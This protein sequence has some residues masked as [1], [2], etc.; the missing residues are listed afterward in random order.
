MVDS[1]P[2][3]RSQKLRLR[4]MGE[5]ALTH[6]AG[7][8]VAIAS[9]K[10]RALLAILA[11]SP[12][13]RASRERL[14]ALLWGEHDDNAA[15]N[16][17]RQALASLRKELEAIAQSPLDPL[18][19]QIVLRPG[20]CAVDA[21]TILEAARGGNLDALR[22]AATLCRGELLE[23]VAVNEEAFEN[24]LSGQRARLAAAAARLF[25]QL[26]SMETGEARVE[27]AQ[28]L[29]ELD[30]LREAS[31][32]QLMMALAATGERALAL[33]QYEMC[34]KV[35]QDE[36]GVA[37]AAETQALRQRITASE[38]SPAQD[39]RGRQAPVTEDRETR[40]PSVAVL[41][42]ANLD[43]DPA[44]SYFSDGVTGDIIS[45]LSR[46]RLI[47]VQ[48]RSASFRYRSSD[49]S[50]RQISR[51]LNVR[52]IVEGS[53][54]RMATRIRVSVQLIDAETGNHAWA[55]RFDR[56]A[57]DIF[58]VQDQVVRTIVST[59]AGRV[60][61]AAVDQVSRKPPAILQA[62]E[63]VLK[64]NLLPWNEPAG[65][66]EAMQLFTR[67]VELDPGYGLA[68]SLLANML[69]VKW[70]DDLA[71]S[72]ATLQESMRL[73][74]HA[75][76]LDS[77]DSTCFSMLAH[78]VIFRGAHDLAIGYARRAIEINPNNQWN[79]ADLG[80]VLIYAGEAAAALDCFTIARENDPYFSPSWLWS[81]LG[82][83]H[84]V[85]RRHDEALAAFEHLTVRDYWVT[86]LMAGCCAR[87]VNLQRASVLAAECLKARPD[88]TIG[89]RIAKEP[90]RIAGDTAYLVESLKLAGLP[91]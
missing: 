15:R 19:D 69:I 35:L 38:A 56:D 58:M 50:I 77:N 72:D 12:D 25:E 11:M 62:Y 59:L 73:A 45:E 88:F 53:V 85:L 23:D 48:S 66:A 55:E 78:T 32:R 44:Q 63:C 86:A 87:V 91:A 84:L 71:G 26:A 5:F 22:T 34:R 18:D 41:P 68:H 36:L 82:L 2:I 89:K 46:W 83:A 7:L 8:S 20:A 4:L 37:P 42:F 29:V 61:V 21:L 80:I 54:R 14:A 57:S 51:E 17:L 10:N 16:S 6:G 33:R 70:K 81:N 47:S 65:A 67:A 1:P 49:L 31:H 13:Q 52:Y 24:W 79:M 64:G 27:A 74:Q 60:Q 43:D 39:Q 76:E 3:G 90:F 40:L 30:P 28:R 9:R 75:V